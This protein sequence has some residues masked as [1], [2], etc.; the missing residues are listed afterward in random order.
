[1][2]IALLYQQQTSHDNDISQSKKPKRLYPIHENVQPMQQPNNK[3][4]QHQYSVTSQD[5]A[6]EHLSKMAITTSP[7]AVNR[8]FD[9]PLLGNA[10]MISDFELPLPTPRIPA[11]VMFYCLKYS[12]LYINLVTIGICHHVRLCSM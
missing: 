1:M 3:R 12:S 2:H 11:S 5:K 4:Q 8:G 10:P 9:I 7:V 6:I